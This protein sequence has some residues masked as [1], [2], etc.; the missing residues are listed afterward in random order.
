[1]LLKRQ[2][3]DMVPIFAPLFLRIGLPK[4]RAVREDIRTLWINRDPELMSVLEDI[5]KLEMKF[6]TRTENKRRLAA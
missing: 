3:G 5:R 6:G 2:V 1:M 4:L